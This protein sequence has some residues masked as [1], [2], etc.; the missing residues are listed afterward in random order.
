M[1]LMVLCLYWANASAN[2][3]SVNLSFNIMYLFPIKVDISNIEMK[4][5]Y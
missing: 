3:A 1:L 5:K 4:C 2:C